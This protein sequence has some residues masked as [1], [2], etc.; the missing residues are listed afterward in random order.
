[1][2]AVAERLFLAHATGAPVVIF[3]AEHYVF[4]LVRSDLRSHG[5]RKF[6]VFRLKAALL[7]FF[8]VFLN[9]NVWQR[10]ELVR[11]VVFEVP[12]ALLDGFARAREPLVHV[13]GATAVQ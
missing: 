12:V 7:Y 5:E 10:G 11:H 6:S 9:R 4:D 1:M 3:S 2:R 8:G 13:V